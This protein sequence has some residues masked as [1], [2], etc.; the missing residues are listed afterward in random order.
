MRP[1][2]PA[3]VGAAVLAGTLGHADDSVVYANTRGDSIDASDA[4]YL[5]NITD[6]KRTTT[7][8]AVQG[9]HRRHITAKVVL[10]GK[11][12]DEQINALIQSI[13]AEA[14]ITDSRPYHLTVTLSGDTHRTKVTI[15]VGC[16]RLCG[17][18]E[19]RMYTVDRGNWRLLY[20][21]GQ[22]VR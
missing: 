17:N 2:L 19:N 11:L 15:D 6:P 7:V 20:S 1:V 10:V 13:L 5:R 14:E 21:W 8:E 16:G 4:A 22:V 9:L 3:I 12:N 18:V